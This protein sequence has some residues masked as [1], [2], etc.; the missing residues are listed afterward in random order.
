[1]IRAKQNIHVCLS[2]YVCW[3]DWPLWHQT[4]AQNRSRSCVELHTYKIS[5]VLQIPDCSG[6]SSLRKHSKFVE[7]WPFEVRK[8]LD[9]WKT[10]TLSIMTEEKYKMPSNYLVNTVIVV[11]AH[12]TQLTGEKVLVETTLHTIKVSTCKNKTKEA[13]IVDLLL[14]H[15]NL[16]KPVFVI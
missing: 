5:A 8:K 7:G 15:V 6:F 13:I 9:Q 3:A 14:L 16:K 10:Q 11:W 12:W 2:K 4:K 1:M